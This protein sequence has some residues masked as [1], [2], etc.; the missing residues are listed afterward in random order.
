[1][2]CRIGMGIFFTCHSSEYG[3]H[4]DVKWNPQEEIEAPLTQWSKLSTG[5]N[6]AKSRIMRG[7][8]K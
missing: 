1:M 4:L 6:Q 2:P 7:R 8:P 5:A 3:N